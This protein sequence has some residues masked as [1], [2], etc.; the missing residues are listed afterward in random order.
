MVDLADR[1]I[2]D[3][4]LNLYERGMTQDQLRL[5]YNI[6]DVFLQTSKAEGLGLPVMEAMACGLAV[7]ATETGA[8]V[9]LLNEGRGVLIA[10]EYTIHHDVWGNSRR[11]FIDVELG[12]NAIV[13]M[14]NSEESIQ[15]MLIAAL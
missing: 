15:P 12:A 14:V 8:M 13:D 1:R 3:D 2:M 10:P 4:I 6:S 11:D 9:E 7:V 5:F